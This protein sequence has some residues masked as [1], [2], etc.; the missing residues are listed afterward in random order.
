MQTRIEVLLSELGLLPLRL[1]ALR[2]VANSRERF[3]RLSQDCP[4]RRTEPDIPLMEE[5]RPHIDKLPR[6]PFPNPAA[7]PLGESSVNVEFFPELT[8]AV[9]RDDDDWIRR[10]AT[11][12]ALHERGR[13]RMHWEIWSDGSADKGTR[14]GGS[15]AVL[16]RDPVQAG[17]TP[18]PVVDPWEGKGFTGV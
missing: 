16:L 9:S 4:A 1:R 2:L 3:L 12:R 5:V 6:E 8:M 11:Y 17:D 18:V 10:E 15:G 14:N 13:D 7:P